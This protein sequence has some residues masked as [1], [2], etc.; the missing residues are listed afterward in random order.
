[1]D[2]LALHKTRLSASFL[3]A[4]PKIEPIFGEASGCLSFFPIRLSFF[5]LLNLLHLNSTKPNNVQPFSDGK[6]HGFYG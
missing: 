4:C 5:E 1:M 3:A 6:L 2:R